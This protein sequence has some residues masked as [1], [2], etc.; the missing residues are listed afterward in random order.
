VDQDAVE[1]C[2]MTKTIPIRL[3]Q[4]ARLVGI[5]QEVAARRAATQR[6]GGARID[7]AGSGHVVS[8]QANAVPRRG[9]VISAA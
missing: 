8:T 7:D 5:E 9:F 3:L 4:L 2:S 1:L 6:Q